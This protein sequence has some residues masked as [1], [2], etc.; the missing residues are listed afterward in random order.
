MK[1][2]LCKI[3]AMAL[4]AIMMMCTVAFA[5]AAMGEPT[6]S[7]QVV[8]VSLSG[9]TAG[10]EATILVVN[11]G[12][13]LASVTKADIVYIDQLT[14]NNEGGVS[15]TMD[16]S[17]AKETD[18]KKYVDIYSGYTNMADGASPLSVKNVLVAGTDVPPAQTVIYGDLDGDKTVT[19]I[20][21]NLALKFSTGSNTPNETEKVIAD[22][23]GDTI[24]TLTDA[25][26][27]VK[28]S[29]GS[30]VKFPVE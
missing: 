26:L 6:V 13:T 24:I 16:A 9:L 27:I 15:F 30:L 5:D 23:D 4:V 19:L 20:D 18:G 22:V 3:M 1:K 21:A 14:V 12:T 10:E 29:T 2:N 25:N 17:A 7:E 28:K 8:T 11:A